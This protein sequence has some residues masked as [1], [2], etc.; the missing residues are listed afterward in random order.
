MRVSTGKAGMVGQP[1]QVL[2]KTGRTHCEACGAPL[3][4]DKFHKCEEPTV[5]VAKPQEPMP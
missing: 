2:H 3:S 5:E 1:P 4:P